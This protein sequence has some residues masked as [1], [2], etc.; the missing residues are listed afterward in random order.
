MKSIGK[1]EN[2]VLILQGRIYFGNYI[3]YFILNV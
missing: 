1:E 2:I 3:V